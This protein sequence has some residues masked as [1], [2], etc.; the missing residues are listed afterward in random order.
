MCSQIRFAM[1]IEDGL[2]KAKGVCVC[3]LC[4]E[5]DTDKKEDDD[6][7]TEFFNDLHMERG[8]SKLYKFVGHP[9]DLKQVLLS[10]DDL[11]Q[12]AY[13]YPMLVY[14]GQYALNSPKTFYAPNGKAF[15]VRELAIA[16]EA[17]EKENQDKL[18]LP[19][20]LGGGWYFEGLKRCDEPHAFSVNWGTSMASNRGGF[21]RH[22]F[23]F[24]PLSTRTSMYEEPTLSMMKGLSTVKAAQDR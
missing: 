8:S 9:S 14:M 7:V 20:M 10:E 1:K 19:M 24:N 22:G 3:R 4:N 18:D 21:G 12:I 23:G 13:P 5:D 6:S 16:I 15:T 11:N 17:A 2:P